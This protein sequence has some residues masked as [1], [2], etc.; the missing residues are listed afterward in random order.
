MEQHIDKGIHKGD[1]E[2][3]MR[4]ALV[5]SGFGTW[6]LD[7]TSNQVTWD[8]RCRELYGYPA[9]G[10]LSQENIRKNIHP[11][12]RERVTAAIDKALRPESGGL[13]DIIFRTVSTTDNQ[14]RWVRCIGKAYFNM[15]LRTV[16][17]V[18]CRMRQENNR[19]Y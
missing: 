10:D 1:N 12:D 11:E 7:L 15:G 2:E 16:L 9:E 18:L 14:L 4:F 17:P 6:E 13:Y 8:D 5:S 19:N 3:W